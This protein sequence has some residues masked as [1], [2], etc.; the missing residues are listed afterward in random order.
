L[1]DAGVRL[2]GHDILWC[3][4]PGP[5]HSKLVG[6]KRFLDHLWLPTGLA[7]LTPDQIVVI[8]RYRESVIHA[9]DQYVYA[10]RA[11]HMLVEA[12]ASARSAALVEIGCGKFPID[13]PCQR[14]LGIDIDAEAIMF[15]QSQ[16]K[17]ACDPAD[18]VTNVPGAI[19]CIVSSYAMHF[20]ISDALIK[21][22][23]EIASADAI[24]C[25]NLIVEDSPSAL[26]IL[27]RL[28]PAWP[29][30]R[31][32]KTSRMA[33]RE[34]FFVVGRPSAWQRIIAAGQAME[35]CAPDGLNR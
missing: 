25:F 17:E 18:L 28:A 12:V 2:L 24:F 6:R 11:R 19:D 26:G 30:F 7:E 23:D 14:Y 22:L 9:E 13:A 4:D 33:R 5:W 15:V 8:N 10:R 31:V 21:D 27:A 16:G 34:F 35:R 29:L 3:A 32:V 20:A 1:S